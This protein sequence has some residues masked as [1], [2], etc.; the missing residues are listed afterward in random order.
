MAKAKKTR[1][2]IVYLAALTRREWSEVVEVPV[3]L[4]GP[5]L[6][7]LVD[8]FYNLIDSGDYGE[9]YEFW[10]QGTCCAEEITD[11]RVQAEPPKY[12]VRRSNKGLI[13]TRAEKSQGD[14]LC[15]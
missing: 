2:I 4:T 15:F 8:D 14:Q 11:L 3:D 5:D 7:Q 1:K 12:K 13:I 6:E 9:D 10:E